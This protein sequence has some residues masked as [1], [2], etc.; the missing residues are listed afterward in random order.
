MMNGDPLKFETPQE[1]REFH[2]HAAKVFLR[3]AQARRT[4]SPGFAQTLLD[5]AANSRQRAAA[6]NLKPKQGE[7]F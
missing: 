2:I 4:R 1:E 7:L 5:W 6:I 3:E